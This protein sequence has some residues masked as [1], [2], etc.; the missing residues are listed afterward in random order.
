MPKRHG[1]TRWLPVVAAFALTVLLVVVALR[2]PIGPLAE[3]T[4][5]GGPGIEEPPLPAVGAVP[6]VPGV[7]LYV[8]DTTFWTYEPSTGEKHEFLRFPTGSYPSSPAASPD[9]TQVAFGLFE[10]GPDAKNPGGGD[11]YVMRS[12][13]TD[14]RKVVAHGAPGEVAVDPVWA[15]DGRNIYYILRRP[16][17]TMGIER[18]ALDGTGRISVLPDADSVTV[19]ASGEWLAYVK[20]DPET[21]ARELW[22]A[23]TDGSGQR[24]IAGEPEFTS[25]ALPR[26]APVGEQIVFGAVGGPGGAWRM[27]SDV[28]VTFRDLFGVGT[29][30]AHGVPWDLWTINAD[31][32]GLRRLTRL[33]EDSPWP[34]WS[35]DGNWIAFA[36]EHGLYLVDPAGQEVRFL[37]EE[38]V[39]GGIDWLGR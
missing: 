17:G 29:A 9:G 20:T 35:P 6:G 32:T 8:R 10:S 2:P 36:A 12:D 19:S 4:T 24:K 13:G 39:T 7:L 27:E 28:R 31:G 38:W 37:A 14:R 34:A 3:P 26:F 16:D 22:V 15:P 5:P 33:A 21:Y 1:Q 11:L 23:R 18:V 30:H 25:L